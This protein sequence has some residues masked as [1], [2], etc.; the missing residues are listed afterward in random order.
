MHVTLVEG[1]LNASYFGVPSWKDVPEVVLTPATSTSTGTSTNALNTASSKPSIPADEYN[2]GHTALVF[3]CCQLQKRLD[4][5]TGV[6]VYKLFSFDAM[7]DMDLKSLFALINLRD[8][9]RHEWEGAYPLLRPVVPSSLAPPSFASSTGASTVEAKDTELPTFQL[10]PLLY[11]TNAFESV[12]ST[13][14]TEML[15][16]RNVADLFLADMT[17]KNY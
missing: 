8:V 2:E 13:M 10:S 3:S 9:V 6:S 1:V 4:N 14:E 11:Y 5:H 16:A 12:F 17:T 15:A 7:S